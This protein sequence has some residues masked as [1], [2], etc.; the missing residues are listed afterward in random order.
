MNE[1]LNNLKNLTGKSNRKI[2]ADVDGDNV[3]VNSSNSNGIPPGTIQQISDENIVSAITNHCPQSIISNVKNTKK[4]HHHHRKMSQ[5]SIRI[6]SRLK[7]PRRHSDVG[8]TAGTSHENDET[9]IARG[10]GGGG[11]S[12]SERNSNSLVSSRESSASLSNRSQ[13][14]RKISIGSHGGGVG[15]IPWCACWGNGCL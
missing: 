1:E 6:T 15:K 10:G 8:G 2:S 13:K 3:V 5:D 4:I 11:T 9:C 14:S 7:N 12:M